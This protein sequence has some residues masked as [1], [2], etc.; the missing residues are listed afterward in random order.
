MANRRM[1]SLD[2]VDTD[3]FLD[4]GSGAQLLYYHLGM[5]ADDDG[6][7]SSPKKIQRNCRA[8]DG[9]FK[10][11]IREGYLI[12]F[13]SGVVVITHWRQNNFIRKDRY[14]PSRCIEEKREL[15]QLETGAYGLAS[16]FHQL[17]ACA[18]IED[19]QPNGIPVV[20]QRSTTRLPDGQPDGNQVV[21]PGKVSLD[22]SSL[23]LGK[24]KDKEEENGAAAPKKRKRFSPPTIEEVEAYIKENGYSVNAEKW[25]SHYESNGWYVGKN[26]MKDWK[27]SV[28]YWNA[29]SGSYSEHSHQAPK[30][31]EIDTTIPAGWE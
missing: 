10:E 4:M 14:T 8:T 12:P 21:Y 19:G 29:N 16:E 31:I 5:H 18:T 6:F 22:K 24:S 11:L 28:R 15:L 3:R 17:E 27:A 30:T 7:V 13:H 25:Y 9:D 2:V 26:K 20:N 23:E 1:F